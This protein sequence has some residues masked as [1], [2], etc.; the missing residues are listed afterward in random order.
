[1]TRFNE[2]NGDQISPHHNLWPIPFSEIERNTGAVLVQNP[3]Y[4]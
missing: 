3:G 4:F 2:Y 1:M